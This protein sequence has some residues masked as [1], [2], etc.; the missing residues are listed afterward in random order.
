MKQIELASIHKLRE[1]IRTINA[2]SLENADIEFL[3]D[4]L[5]LLFA[6]YAL[7]TPIVGKGQK[8][9]RAVR[10]TDR[11]TEV[12][13]LSYPPPILVSNY[14][15]ANR[16]NQSR[17]YASVSRAAVFFE[18]RARPGDHLAVSKWRVKRDILVNNVGFSNSVWDLYKTS[19][20]E[21]NPSW[22][23]QISTELL[24]PGNRLVH[25]FLARIFSAQVTDGAEYQYKLSVAVAEKLL[26]EVEH[27]DHTGFSGIVYPSLAM[28]ANSDNLVLLPDAVDQCL[29][30]EEVEFI[31][32]EEHDGDLQYQVKVLDF[33]NSFEH[34][35]AWKG[36]DRQWILPG[37]SQL[38]FTVDEQGQWLAQDVEGR[39]VSPD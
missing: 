31:H 21:R 1:R 12:G 39:F 10:R 36:R 27:P 4:R 32:V 2:M 14:G 26:G 16:P 19:R 15:R 3:K 7:S 33:A 23:S 38:M 22:V 24:S 20:K 34:G 35:I 25:D 18:L 29:E 30:L 13:Q 6:G 5:T 11:P 8:L 9:F 28:K 37:K 17:F